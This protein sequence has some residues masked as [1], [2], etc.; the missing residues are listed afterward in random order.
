MMRMLTKR[1][2]TSSDAISDVSVLQVLESMR[3]DAK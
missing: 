2:A 3:E 1:Y